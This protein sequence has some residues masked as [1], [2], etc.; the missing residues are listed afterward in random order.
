M[1]LSEAGKPTIEAVLAE[2]SAVKL[3]EL[4]KN[5]Y[6]KGY[7]KMNKPALVQAVSAALREPGRMEELLYIIDQPAFLLFKRAAKRRE[8]VKVKKALPEQCGLLEDLGYLVCDASQEDL[9][10]TV[11]TEISEVFHQLEREGFTER[12]VRYDLLDSYAMAAVHL[13][14]AIS[15][16]DCG[17]LQPA[18][19]PAHHGRGAVPGVAP[20]C[21][22]RRTLLLLGGVYRLRRVRGE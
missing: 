7:S 19:Q 3:K 1:V 11:P 17:H 18:E 20:P 22:R 10:V 13:Y 16:P 5:Y 12:K 4:A 6:V 15:Q 9:I 21:R 14:G 8:P 2:A